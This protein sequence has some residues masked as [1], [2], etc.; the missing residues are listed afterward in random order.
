MNFG[1]IRRQ[2][3]LGVFLVDLTM[4]L[5]LVVNLGF[6]LFDSLL[7]FG[8]FGNALLAAAPDFTRWYYSTVAPHFLFIDLLFI[9]VFLLEFLIRWG[10]AVWVKR[11]HRWFFFPFVHWYDLIGLVPLAGFRILRLLRI[12]SIILRLQRVGAIDITS[13]L[14][15]RT[16]IKYYGILIQ[17]LTDRVTINILSRLQGEARNGTPVLEHIIDEVVVPRQD[18]L[19]EWLSKRVEQSLGRNFDTYEAQLKRYVNHRLHTAIKVNRD[20][21]R[22]ESIP[23][24]G[25]QV[26]VTV[27][28]TVTDIVNRVV[29]DTLQ[30]LASVHNR[31]FVNEVVH[32]VFESIARSESDDKLADTV[33]LTITEA[34]DIVKK[35]VAIKQWQIRDSAADEEEFRRLLRD[36]F[37]RV[38]ASDQR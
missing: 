9:S 36:E 21:A 23:V 6:I 16:L 17:E 38:A 25:K 3:Q 18:D 33:V 24:L 2:G 20:V 7:A 15:L 8:W 35:H 1:A 26:R 4:V 22:M 32:I 11:H 5:L 28:K 27:E 31:I 12:V 19:V 14:L 10:I 13:W 30:D 37:M 34:I 29:S